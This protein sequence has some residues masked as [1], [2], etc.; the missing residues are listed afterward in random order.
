MYDQGDQ[1]LFEAKY[2]LTLYRSIVFLAFP[3]FQESMLVSKKGF[4]F[5][6]GRKWQWRFQ[7][8][9]YFQFCNCLLILFNNKGK[10]QK[11][12]KYQ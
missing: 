3:S 6:V 9:H 8:H 1:T 12:S 7:V 2:I 10:A 4:S 11:L 5:L